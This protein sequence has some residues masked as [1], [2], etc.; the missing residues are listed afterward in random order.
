M[1]Q[2]EGEKEHNGSTPADGW[3]KGGAPGE[4][5]PTAD[6]DYKSTKQRN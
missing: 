3:T 4:G 5:K 1:E 6:T 2:R